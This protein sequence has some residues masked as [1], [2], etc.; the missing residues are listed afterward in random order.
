MMAPPALRTKVSFPSENTL[1]N[2][3]NCGISTV[4][5]YI[6]FLCDMKMLYMKN[7]H[8]VLCML[9]NET[10]VSLMMER[11]FQLL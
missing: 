9:K 1:S 8:A 3:S 11:S 10:F 4:K 6:Q 2:K 7:V 5:K